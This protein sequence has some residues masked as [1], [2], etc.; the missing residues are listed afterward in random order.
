[1]SPPPE[2]AA[3][4]GARRLTHRSTG[5]RKAHFV[6]CF[7]PVSSTVIAKR[8]EAE[9]SGYERTQDFFAK[10]ASGWEHFVKKE[11]LLNDYEHYYALLASAISATQDAIKIL[12]LGCGGGIEFESIFRQAPDVQITSVDQSG[13]MLDCLRK[14]Y[15]ERLGQIEIIQ[16]SYLTCPLEEEAYD[17]VVT[18]MSVHYFPPP[19][20]CEIYE[21]IVRALKCDGAYIEGTYCSNSDEEEHQALR[22]FRGGTKGLAGADSG[23]WKVNIPMQSTTISRLLSEAGF[24]NSEWL[25]DERWVVVACKTA[26]RRPKRE[27]DQQ[28]VN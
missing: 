23:V 28:G 11:W 8:P 20:R 6:R 7:G 14:K 17:Y 4:S 19:K 18:S 27:H 16:D 9:L 25:A 3:H 24:A 22:E 13:P 2:L 5:S 21:R 12:D 10:R 26:F 15:A 1:M